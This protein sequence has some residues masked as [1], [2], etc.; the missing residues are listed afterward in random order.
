MVWS[1]GA[2]SRE[3]KQPTQGHTAYTQR[4]KPTLQ[5]S[6]LP[7]TRCRLWHHWRLNPASPF[8]GL[9][10]LRRQSSCAPGC[11]GGRPKPREVT[12]LCGGFW[13]PAQGS[14]TAASVPGVQCSHPSWDD[15]VSGWARGCSQPAGGPVPSVPRTA[16]GHNL[17]VAPSAL[18]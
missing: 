10:G 6:H 5:L 13:L 18:L 4:T 15:M 12:E 9:Q 11:R 17:S 2:N 3:V 8:P 1:D 7:A 16:T 14:P